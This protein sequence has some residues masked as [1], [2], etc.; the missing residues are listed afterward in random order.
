MLYYIIYFG[1]IILPLICWKLKKVAYFTR[2]SFVTTKNNV[3][4]FCP[5]L[6]TN[7]CTTV[8]PKV[9]GRSRKSGLG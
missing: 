9:N 7:L 2:T 3:T 5:F 1:Y 8:T 6:S 4:D